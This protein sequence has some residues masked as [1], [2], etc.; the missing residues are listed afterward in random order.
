MKLRA[1]QTWGAEMQPGVGWR[2][3]E[4]GIGGSS[5]LPTEAAAGAVVRL[6]D[7]CGTPH[8]LLRA[9]QLLETMA[10]HWAFN[11][12]PGEYADD[13]EEEDDIV[14]PGPEGEWSDGR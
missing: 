5:L 12:D 11:I 9:A 1:W 14:D 10:L 6:V 2:A 7:D 13:L 8:E 3:D 4:E